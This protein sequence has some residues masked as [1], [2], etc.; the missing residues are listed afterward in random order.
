M[1]QKNIAVIGGGLVGLATAYQIHQKFPAAHII[2]IE[3]EKTPAQHQ[4]SHN[5]GV[6][7]SGIYYL[8]HSLKAKNCIAG[9]RYLLDFCNENQVPYKITGKLIVAVRPEE[10]QALRVLE[11]RAIEN[12]LEGVQFLS[13]SE[14]NL[15][16]PAIKVHSALWVPQT[17]IID[18]KVLATK[19]V[20]ILSAK[21]VELKF[22]QKVSAI[23]QNEGQ[24]IIHTNQENVEV[25]FAVNC[26]GLYSDKIA[27]MA[28]AEIQ[29]QIIPFRGEYFM[30]NERIAQ[31][32]N[33]LVYP[34]PQQGLPFLGVH[35][36]RMINGQVEAGPNAILAFRRE[37]YQRGAFS[38]KDTWEI[39]KFVGFWKMI[40]NF[41]QIGFTEWKKSMSKK[42]FT[43]TV[44]QLLPE[45]KEEDLTPATSGVR[46]QAIHENGSLIDDFL[47]ITS[48]KMIHVCN[49]P[50]PAATSCLAIGE[51]IANELKVQLK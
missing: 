29:H 10:E 26:A 36:T 8:P 11:K 15:I 18:F 38:F 50:S 14:A 32:I 3:K 49:A 23:T 16:E 2:L 24:L 43:K 19:F 9:Y 28:G 42:A 30:I 22:G 25:D 34:V 5:S 44:Q 4:S 46:A 39:L 7:H 12:G 13:G 17:G 37:G 20:E 27:R 51:T 41:R 6:I 21:G 47:L 1:S 31:K 45:I 48:P 33:G 35:L 40:F